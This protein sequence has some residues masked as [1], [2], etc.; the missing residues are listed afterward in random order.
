M[1]WK[2]NSDWRSIFKR[3]ARTGKTEIPPTE[4]K[5]KNVE[6]R[7]KR[8]KCRNGAMGRKE[9]ENV[10]VNKLEPRVN[11]VYR[12]QIW[13]MLKVIYRENAFSRVH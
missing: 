6:T 10:R 8:N 1:L 11:R 9:K 2:R 13:P 12:N 5:Q 4:S 3:C 7:V